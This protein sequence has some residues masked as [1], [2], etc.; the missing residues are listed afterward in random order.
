MTD[1]KI[2]DIIEVH[3]RDIKLN[4]LNTPIASLCNKSPLK[5]DLK[6]WKSW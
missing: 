1:R 4:K 2:E 3:K 5:V 6:T